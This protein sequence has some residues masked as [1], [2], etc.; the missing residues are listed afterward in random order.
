MRKF[1]YVFMICVFVVPAFAVGRS[2]VGAGKTVSKFGSLTRSS[3]Q[4]ANIIKKDTANNTASKESV[5]KKETVNRD[6]ERQACLSNNIGV[7]NTFVWAS[8]TSNLSNYATMLEDIDHPENNTCF[9]LVGMR[10][11]DNRISTADIQPRYFEWGQS[12]TCGSWIDESKM[13]DRILE[14]K[15]KARVWGTIAGSVGG[16]GVGV[17]SME[18][19]GNRLIGGAVQGQEQ[20]KKYSQ[21]W[22]NAKANQL[23]KEYGENEYNEFVEEARKLQKFCSEPVDDNREKCNNP[24]YKGVIEY[25]NKYHNSSNS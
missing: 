14:A 17:G 23:K 22:F 7:G 1:L 11:D 3:V 4:S 5:S 24:R 13:Q 15:K 21:E 12:I 20:Y 16:A 2:M 19:F 18:L 25:Y 6:K 10:S 9:A 8:K